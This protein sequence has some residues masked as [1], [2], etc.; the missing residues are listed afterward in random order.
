MS[1]NC[2]E[3]KLSLPHCKLVPY[4][5]RV[6]LPV[7]VLQQEVE[8]SRLVGKGKHQ[9]APSLDKAEAYQK[10]LNLQEEHL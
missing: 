10:V 6:V 7:V 2:C 5:W 9:V 4:W 3:L 1:M 8:L